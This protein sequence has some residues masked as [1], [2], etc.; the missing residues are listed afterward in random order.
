ME[1]VVVLKLLM[2]VKVE[3]GI[4]FLHIIMQVVG[5]GGFA[6]KRAVQPNFY[7]NTRANNETN[8]REYKYKWS[9]VKQTKPFY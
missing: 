1:V 9:L 4:T 7:K 5:R 2:R 6:V 3:V 8:D